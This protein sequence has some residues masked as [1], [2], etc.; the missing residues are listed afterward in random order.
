MLS[1]NVLLVVLDSVRAKN[2]SLYGYDR[3]TTPNLDA[4]A[5]E[6]TVYEQA[7]APGTGS[8]QSHVSMFT[9]LH[10]AEHRMNG[11][12][13]SI[14]P[15]QTIWRDL[16]R[17]GYDTGVFS[18]NTYLTQ[19]PIGLKQAFDLVVAGDDR[20]PFPSAVDPGDFPA[21]ASVQE[22]LDAAW[23]D[24]SL[25]RSF[26]NG[27]WAKIGGVEWLPGDTNVDDRT[28]TDR[29]LEWR[30]AS[31][32]PWAACVNLMSAHTPYEPRREHDRWATDGAR[33]LAD[34]VDHWVWDFVGVDDS[35]TP[36]S[37]LEDLYDGGIHQ[38]DAELGRLI[39]GLKNADEFEDTL[40]VVLGD[41]GEGFGEP[42]EVRDVP[43]IGHGTIGGVEEGVMRVPLVVHFPSQTEGT[44][45][46]DPA[47]PARFPAVVRHVVEDDW[48]HAGFVPNGQV[49]ASM[50]PVPDHVRER[51]PD[52][53]DLGRYESRARV[54]YTTDGQRVIKH[55]E[56]G[57]RRA[58]FD[59]T[60]PWEAQRLDT[61]VGT[62]LD[63]AFGPLDPAGGV[64]DSGESVSAATEARLEALGYR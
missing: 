18:Y 11:T 20:L 32:G 9:G 36:L 23:R 49:V 17:R 61:D 21:E 43:S 51:A 14:D 22:F 27:I 53:V 55:V 41:H 52:R 7:R 39:E 50:L 15:A 5:E 37:Q 25:P 28:F 1:P 13:R 35:R 34:K 56:C 63:D 29:F 45:V 58:R 8:V 26:I 60:D 19:A 12:D 6:A 46:T 62:V 33:E 47:T 3:E 4:L 59:C 44:S 31:D 54:A 2:T 40:L 16:A 64:T 48:S 30:A 24:R 42:G 10:V 57:G 38:A